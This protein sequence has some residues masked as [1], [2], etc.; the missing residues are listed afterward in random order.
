MDKK[1]IKKI[2]PATYN[3]VES[4]NNKL[5]HQVET[6]LERLEKEQDRKLKSEFEELNDQNL[7]YEKQTEEFIKEKANVLSK[8]IADFSEY[9]T[10]EIN[11]IKQELD[12]KIKK[13]LEANIK[14][15]LE[16]KCSEI[17]KR[18]SDLQA[19]NKSVS[20]SLN[21]IEHKY[22]YN[23]EYERK[24]IRSFDEYYKRDDFKDMFLALV[25]G[26]SDEDKAQIVRIL[27]RQRLAL[28]SVG[29]ETDIFTKEEQQK[30]LE[31]K[32]KMGINEFRVADDMYCL[33]Q[34]FLPVKHFEASVFFYKH[35]IDCIENIEALKN[36]DILDVGG[37]IGDS[38]LILKPLT[39]KRVFSFEAL[40]EHYELMKKT[41][42]MNQLDNV[43]L[44]RMALGDEN[45]E[46]DIEVAGSSSSIN[47]NEAVEIHGSEKVMMRTLDS[48][49]EE[50]PMDI[51][52]IKVD[53][54]GA[55]QQFMKGAKKTIEK[56]R[57]V[58]LM[59]IYHNADD[60]FH[61]KP[62]IESWNLGYKFRIHKPVDFSISREVL[63]IAEVR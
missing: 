39:E 50:H 7:I 21:H 26:L 8:Q 15:E 36:K 2:V 34:Y 59:S 40:K 4:S 60:F 55:E 41:V 6:M 19:Q 10:V 20:Q 57:P 27:Q 18:I 17:Q 48:Y 32:K 9:I 11:N 47:P 63:L 58:L 35:G 45:K 44:E 28:D 43:I 42:A 52:L 22:L 13:E 53:I 29:R 24:A 3:K 61:I 51:G 37:F 62:I 12:G 30:I 38:I 5:L 54:E 56:Y 49:V 31:L 1:M 25:R 46:I 16:T 33:N 23:N 14:R